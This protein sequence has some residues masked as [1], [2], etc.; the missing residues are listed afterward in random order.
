[1]TADFDMLYT[2]Y[3]PHKKTWPKHQKHAS[4]PQCDK[5]HSPYVHHCLWP[6]RLNRAVVERT[7]WAIFE[8]AK[9]NIRTRPPSIKSRRSI[10]PSFR[11]HSTNKYPSVA[12][13]LRPKTAPVRT[14]WHAPCRW[15]KSHDHN[16]YGALDSSWSIGHIQLFSNVSC[17]EQPSNVVRT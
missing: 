3:Q 5:T 6:T 17:L 1:M 8:T 16:H 15:E 9:K 11:I 14:K 13:T 4:I 7:E 2:F 12:N 10:S